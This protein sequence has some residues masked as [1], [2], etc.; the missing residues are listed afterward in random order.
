MNI[1]SN[2]ISIVT[3]ILTV[4]LSCEDTSLLVNCEECY[5]SE[6]QEAEIEIKLEDDPVNFSPSVLVSIYE[7]NIEDNALLTSFRTFGTSSSYSVVLNK[8]YSVK[9]TYTTNNGITYIAVDSAIPR[10]KYEK[11]QCDENCYYVYDRVVDLRIKYT[12]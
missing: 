9:A 7:G 4:L 5:T 11:S 1:H 6:P 2:I 10:V 12:K 8:K 3:I